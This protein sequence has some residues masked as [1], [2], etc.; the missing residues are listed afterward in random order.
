MICKLKSLQNSSPAGFFLGGGG[1]GA[2]AGCPTIVPARG[3][4]EK[5]RH[6]PLAVQRSLIYWHR[7]T[8]D[9]S[10]PSESDWIWTQGKIRVTERARVK[11]DYRVHILPDDEANHVEDTV[12]QSGRKYLLRGTGLGGGGFWLLL[13]STEFGVISD[14]E[15]TQHRSSSAWPTAICSGRSCRTRTVHFDLKVSNSCSL[16]EALAASRL[17]LWRVNSFQHVLSL[18]LHSI[19]NSNGSREQ[20]LWRS[21]TNPCVIYSVKPFKKPFPLF[22]NAHTMTLVRGVPSVRIVFVSCGT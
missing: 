21:R 4:T 19:Q 22:T 8:Y 16:Q 17:C 13:E 11:C 3:T 10:A 20:W 9:K 14:I 2:T 18:T 5:K 6:T 7:L 15:T 1:G 12:A